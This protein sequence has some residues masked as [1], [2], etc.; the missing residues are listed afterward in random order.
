M[1]G[2]LFD[3]MLGKHTQQAGGVDPYVQAYERQASYAMPKLYA[4]A[5]S[6]I[7]A[8]MAPQFSAARNT[9][10]VNPYMARSG[11]ANAMNR[12]LLQ[13]AYGNLSSSMGETS[14]GATRGA[15]DLYGDLVRRRVQNELDIQ[16]AKAEAKAQK[17]SGLGGFVGGLAGSFLGPVGSAAGKYLGEKVF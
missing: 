14:A 15:L 4:P 2:R 16:R 1:A 5:Y 6:Q 8:Q 12:R 3:S 9:L 17:G 11:A 10:A 7:S 13:T